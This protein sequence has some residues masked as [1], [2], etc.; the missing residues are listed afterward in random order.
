MAKAKQKYYA[1]HGGR[2]GTQIYMTWDEVRALLG[3]RD[4]PRAVLLR[5]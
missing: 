2:E 1:V 4:P 5:R 3:A